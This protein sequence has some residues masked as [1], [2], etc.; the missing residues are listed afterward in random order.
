MIKWI[1]EY[2]KRMWKQHK[3]L[4]YA[5]VAMVLVRFSFVDHYRVPTGSMIPTIM[6]G[7]DIFVYKM[8]YNLRFPLTDWIVFEVQKPKR[9]DIVVFKN[10]KDPSILFVKRLIG[11]PGDK[12][13][14]INGLLMVNG[15][16]LLKD[17]TVAPEIEE[18]LTYSYTP[19]HFREQ[20]GDYEY[21]VQRL[22][23]RFRMENKEFVIPENHYFFVGDNRDNSDDS[24]SWGM[25]PYEHIK[26]KAMRVFYNF[27]MEDWTPSFAWRRIAKSLYESKQGE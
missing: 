13:K 1:K 27:T 5:I 21:T 16:S 6:I 26:G 2:L 9:G 10:P 14:S 8:A 11:L 20:Y 12:V 17:K 18:K 24:R 15:E 22:P 19:F 25:V 3:G 23:D 7:D 4:V